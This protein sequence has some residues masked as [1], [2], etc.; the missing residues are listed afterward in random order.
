[1]K[2]IIPG[3]EPDP[4]QQ[5]W[6]PDQK[7]QHWGKLAD[8]MI[9]RG[10]IKA[11]SMEEMHLRSEGNVPNPFKPPS[12][13][14]RPDHYED[15]AEFNKWVKTQTQ[16][17]ALSKREY[18]PNGLHQ[19]Q[20]QLDIALTKPAEADATW[21]PD[22]LDLAK[23]DIIEN[24]IA[25]VYRQRFANGELDR[26]QLDQLLQGLQNRKAK[27]AGKPVTPVN[28]ANPAAPSTPAAQGGGA[29]TMPPLDSLFK[30]P[31]GQGGG[32]PMGGG[33]P[34]NPNNPFAPKASPFR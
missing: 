30:R 11:G 22:P 19:Q 1:M 25:G 29:K 31:P 33:M 28:P 32:A 7:A 20:A 12:G 2:G 6:T 34:A 13:Y 21:K 24:E 23:V 4:K 8:D 26:A 9:A 16:S 14:Q 3:T 27:R 17:E 15:Q 10:L 18:G 5:T